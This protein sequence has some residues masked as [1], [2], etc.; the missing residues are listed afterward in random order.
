MPI[1]TAVEDGMKVARREGIPLLTP[2]E[3]GILDLTVDGAD[4]VDPN[5]DLI[6]GYGRAL[7]R[8]KVVAASS[9][10]LVVLVGKEKL[11]ARLGT[12]VTTLLMSVA[13]TYQRIIWPGDDALA[14]I[15]A[16]KTP[17]L[18]AP[19]PCRPSSS[20]VSSTS[21]LYITR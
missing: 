21:L 3:A 11:V 6:K 17:S 5:L 1:E 9:R 19:S 2:A 16:P 20:S 14:G 8:E 15:V 10:R 4:E 12:R 7:V 13:L 18:A